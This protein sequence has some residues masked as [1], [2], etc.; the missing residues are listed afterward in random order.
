MSK[1]ALLA[2]DQVACQASTDERSRASP[3]EPG[4][5]GDAAHGALKVK[6]VRFGRR[7]AV[8]GNEAVHACAR[9][10]LVRVVDGQVQHRGSVRAKVLD[11]I[12]LLV[13]YVNQAGVR[14][15]RL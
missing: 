6:V 11:A 14:A 5:K 4:L 1:P 2:Q 10:E 3:S 13:E 12:A 9:Y 8:N 15:Q 7:E